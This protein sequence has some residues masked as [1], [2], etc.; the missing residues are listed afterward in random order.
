MSAEVAV[1]DS[2][3]E[4]VGIGNVEFKPVP[5]AKPPKTSNGISWP[6]KKNAAVLRV[7]EKIGREAMD[8]IKEDWAVLD[9][10]NG[11][12][13]QEKANEMIIAL[14]NLKLSQIEILSVLGCGSE[15]ISKMRTRI[16][17]GGAFVGQGRKPPSHAFKDPTLKYLYDFMD[18]WETEISV[19]CQHHEHKYFV[20]DGVTWKMLHE[21]YQEAYST[22]SAAAKKDIEFMKYSTFTQY[23]HQRN[24]TLRLTRPKQDVCIACNIKP[25]I[26]DPETSSSSSASS[27]SS[28]PPKDAKHEAKEAKQTAVYRPKLLKRKASELESDHQYQSMKTSNDSDSE[29]GDVVDSSLPDT[30]TVLPPLPLHQDTTETALRA[31]APSVASQIRAPPAAA[32]SSPTSK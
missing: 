14:C 2:L 18:Q 30:L 19:Q 15:R 25:D 12:K 4:E 27:S 23:V 29:D 13:D 28:S 5:E 1:N 3:P 6:A 10:G 24:P 22:L 20:E 9:S 17:L 8:L 31:P 16:A 21:R 32:V 26:T 7:I 11:K